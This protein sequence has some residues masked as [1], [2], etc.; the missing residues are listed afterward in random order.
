MCG[1]VA[2]ISPGTA[3]PEPILTRMRD[4]LAHRGPDGAAN[5]SRSYDGG[6]VSFGFRRLSIIDIRH[7]ADQPMISSD[8]KKAIVFNGEIYNYREIRG[9]LEKQG[10]IF[11]T[12]SDTEVLL[13]AYE[14]WGEDMVHRLNGMFA[15]V[16]WDEHTQ[17]A[18]IARD[19]F[20]EKPLFY[21]RLP[22]GGIV[23]GSEIK[24]VV[25]HPDIDSNIDK[26]LLS[27]VV[28]GHLLFGQE[29]TLFTGVR[30]FNSSHTMLVDLSGK[31][32]GYRR[33]W[34]PQYDESLRDVPRQEL[35]EQFRS[36]LEKSIRLRMHSD[37]SMTACL[38]GGLD[39]SGIV[40]VLAKLNKSQERPIE[41]AISARFPDDPTIDEG[42]FINQVLQQTGFEGHSVTPTV[43][44]LLTDIRKLHWH[45]EGV[46]PGASMYLE[47]AVMKQARGLGYKAIL[48]GQGADEVLGGYRS[49]FQAY[50]AELY[51]EGRKLS[52]L[53]LGW[54]RDFRLAR[55]AKLYVNSE[56]RFTKRDGLGRKALKKYIEHHAKRLG[57]EYSNGTF[58]PLNEIGIFRFELALNLL[59]IDLPSNVYSGDRNSMAHGIESRYPYLDYELVDFATHLP[60]WAYLDE[61]WS[62]RILRESLEE[63]I[64]EDV[65]WRVD[66]VGFAAPQDYW[67]KHPQM[68]AWL[69]ERVL[70][71]GLEEI[72]G[73]SRP[74][75]ENHLRKHLAGEADRSSVLWHWASAAELLDMERAG[76]WSDV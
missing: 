25:A 62:K 58:L 53:W 64:P 10:R 8:G 9:E 22:N 70:D 13:Q 48:D 74:G 47:W 43:E 76:V 17:K 31:M 32:H 3:V 36:L 24:A 51:N 4:R 45:H 28:H 1:F 56:R 42:T 68:Q 61:A 40:G 15:F 55:A 19:R 12:K 67:L 7:I 21:A 75:M 50:Q 38:S 37:V 63:V 49:H 66:K 52:S 46:I 69:Q 60:D 2:I 26:A 54:R 59:K 30:Q 73:Y 57:N 34:T 72:E 5:W 14:T 44:D 23:L 71:K 16:I 33:Y 27:K 20:G 41:S 11:Q 6:S 39:S 18:F 29:Q 65:C 35:I